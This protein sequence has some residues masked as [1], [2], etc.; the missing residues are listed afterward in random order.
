MPCYPLQVKASLESGDII[1]E[2]RVTPTQRKRSRTVYSTQPRSMVT[3]LNENLS[4]G[5]RLPFF[6]NSSELD[7][8]FHVQLSKDSHPDIPMR[9]KQ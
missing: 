3:I 2:R 4:L 1:D 9:S 5:T 7:R 6:T 8:T